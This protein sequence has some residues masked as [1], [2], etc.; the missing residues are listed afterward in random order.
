VRKMTEIPTHIG[1]ILDGN[2]RFAKELLKKP[3]QG[4]KMGLEKAR[5]VLKWSCE[6]G[7]K[8][9]TAYTLSFENLSTRPKAE[10]RYILKYLGMEADNI[11][12]DK[13]H[14]VHK[15]NVK[16]RFIG[17]LNL[18]PDNLQEKLKRVEE[19]TKNNNDY[20]LNIALA[21]GGQQE[22]VDAAKEILEKGLKG[23]IR[24]SDLNEQI[25]KEHLYTNGQPLPDLIV[26]T[27]GEKRLSNFLSFQS[28][29][30]ELI[31]TNKKW[32]ELTRRDFN[33]FLREFASRKRRFG[34]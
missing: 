21:Y 2:T 18:L 29:Y 3:W 22:I 5:E 9:M 8:Y 32:P 30:S 23:I 14:T 7:I 15:F 13:N 27:G 20:F 26:R 6:A 31:F 4:H 17:R 25:I 10:L 19:L 1:I 12:S 11:L 33:S 16:V 28:A 24:P 34:S